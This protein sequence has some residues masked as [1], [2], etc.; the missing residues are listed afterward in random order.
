MTMFIGFS[1]IIIGPD[2][3]LVLRFGHARE[4]EKKGLYQM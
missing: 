4:I 3:V 2:V 1:G